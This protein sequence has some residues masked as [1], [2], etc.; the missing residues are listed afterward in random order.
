MRRTTMAEIVEVA[1]PSEAVIFK[2]WL[3]DAP[4]EEISD[5]Y[6]MCDSW[7]YHQLY[8][9]G[10]IKKGGVIEGMNKEGEMER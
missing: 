9:C 10:V 4:V 3:K 1:T 8:I 5:W 7:L 2:C 6:E